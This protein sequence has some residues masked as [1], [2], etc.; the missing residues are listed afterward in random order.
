VIARYTTPEMKRLWSDENRYRRWLEV[1]LLACEAWA[2]LG[3]LP[4]DE[5]AELRQRCRVDTARIDAIE[6]TVKHDV[7][8]FVTAVAETAGRAG[9]H[10]HFGLTSYDV[11]DTALASLMQEAI[12]LISAETSRLAAVVAARAREHRRTLMVG[13]THGVHAEPMT[14]G[15]KFA[16]WYAELQRNLERLARARAVISYGKLSGAVGTYAHVDPRVEA[17]V[18]ARL[19]LQVAPISTQILQ[20]DRHAE[21]VGALAIAATSIE[22]FAT[23][24]RGLQRTEL[25]ELE[26]PFSAGQKGSS[27]MPHKRNPVGCEQMSGLAR[28]VR[29]YAEVAL[30][31]MVL[32]HERD[33][34]NSSAERLIIP[35]STTLVHYMTRRFTRIIEELAVYPERMLANLNLTGGLIYS[36]QVL[37]GLVA[38]GLDREQAYAIVQE[39]AMRAWE[40]KGVFTELV[41]ADPRVRAHLDPQALAACFDPWRQLEHVDTVFSRLGL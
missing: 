31:N 32:W 28:V 24:V 7:I 22:K 5:V 10:L 16:L 39:L 41:A 33:I 35:G 4:A 12:D 30:E 34:S 17:E 18:C 21:Y 27:A 26:E 1:E 8:A 9:R 14:L 36:Q 23:E 11:V 3:V 15:L 40:G 37:L 6:A 20:R 2:R 19:G 29:S 38:A 13:R 25:L